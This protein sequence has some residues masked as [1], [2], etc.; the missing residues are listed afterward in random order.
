MRLPHTVRLTPLHYATPEYYEGVSGYRRIIK[1]E[2]SWRGKR[3]F[4]QFDGAA[5]IAQV[6]LNGALICEHRCGYTAFR[7]ELTDA[8]DWAGENILAVRL[9]STE[10]AAIPPFGFVIDYLTYGGLYREAWLDVR[11]ENYI[12][13][14]FVTTPQRPPSPPRSEPPPRRA[15]CSLRSRIWPGACLRRARARRAP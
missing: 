2:E 9:D 6:Y 12:E 4:V 10:N 11:S 5:H 7:A 8:L 14:V 13:D 1:P 15:A 3:V